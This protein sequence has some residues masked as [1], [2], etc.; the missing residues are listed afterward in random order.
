MKKESYVAMTVRNLIE[1][2]YR[3]NLDKEITICG[4]DSFYIYELEDYILIDHTELVDDED[5]E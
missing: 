2:L 3:L 4:S 5:G 1:E